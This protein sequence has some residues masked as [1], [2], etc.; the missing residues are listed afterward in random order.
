[1]MMMMILKKVNT[2]SVSNTLKSQVQAYMKRKRRILLGESVSPRNGIGGRILQ[3][4]KYFWY[5]IP[6]VYGSL[7]EFPLSSPPTTIISDVTD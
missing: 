1:M 5:R 4:R 2:F 7:S 6:E 3:R